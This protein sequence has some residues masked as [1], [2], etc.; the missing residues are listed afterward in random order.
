MDSIGPI[1][2]GYG[3]GL[4]L[5]TGAVGGSASERLRITSDGKL[6]LGTSAPEAEL[7]ISKNVNGTGL[8]IRIQNTSTTNFTRGTRL[9]FNVH[10][11]TAQVDA[12]YITGLKI[13]NTVGGAT[14]GG[15]LTFS[16]ANPSWDAPA[17]R[18]RIDS[19]GRVGIGTTSPGAALSISKDAGTGTQDLLT[20]NN[21]NTTY[22]TGLGP[23]IQFQTG[24]GTGL[25]S[26]SSQMVGDSFSLGSRFNITNRAG[27]FGYFDLVVN[28]SERLRVDSSGRLLVGTSSWSATST[29]VFSGN[30][31]GTANNGVLHIVRGNTAANLTS[32]ANIGK[33][34][35]S[36]SAAG[37]FAAIEVQAD[38]APGA[39]DYPGR[40][41]FS[42][43]ADG[44]ASPTERLRIDNAGQVRV[45]GLGTAASPALVV[46]GD[47]NT[48]LY[49]PGAD[50][51]AISTNGT[52]RLFVD[53]S[54]VISIGA[55]SNPNATARFGVTGGVASLLDLYRTGVAGEARLN[56]YND[57]SASAATVAGRIAGLLTTTTAGS[58]SGALLFV[59]NNSGTVGER[60]R[61]TAEGRLGLGTTTGIGGSRASILQNANAN[62]STTFTV[63]TTP[64]QLAI[65]DQSD[66]TTY[67]N[68]FATLLL[69]AGSLGAA[70]STIT[71]VRESSQASAIAFGTSAGAGGSSN[72]IERV[73]IDST[74][75]LGLGTS[76]P[77]NTLELIGDLSNSLQ[78]K[79]SINVTSNN[80]GSNGA[81]ASPSIGFS[82][83]YSTDGVRILY[84]LISAGKENGNSGNTQGYLSFYTSPVSSSGAVER[85][86]IDSTGRVGI[87]TTTPAQALDV[88]GSIAA[89]S[90]VLAGAGTAA[91]PAFSFAGDPDGGMFRP[92]VNQ[93]AFATLGTEAFRVNNS[94]RLLVGTSTSIGLNDRIQSHGTGGN[95]FGLGRFVNSGA[96]PDISFYKSR[97]GTVG[98]NTLVQAGDGL[99]N[100][101]FRGANGSTSYL[102]GATIATAVEGTPGATSMGCRLTFST[103]ADGASSPTER[104]RIDSSGNVGI[105]A[106]APTSKLHV[107]GGIRST[108]LNAVGTGGFFNAANKFG[109]DNN[110]GTTRFYSSGSNASTRGS[111]DFRIT[112]SVGSLDTSAMVLTSA[113][114]VGITVTSPTFRLELPNTATDEGG[115][116]RANQWATYSDGRIKTDREDLPYGIDAV[117][118]LEPLRYFHHNSTINEDGTIEILEEGEVSIGLVAQ[119]VDNIIP[120]VVSVPEDLTKDLC[121]LD[122]AKL[123]AVLVKAIQEQQAMIAELQTKVAALEAS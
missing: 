63:S 75:R 16:T 82:A 78:G 83:P 45:A 80:T 111:Y 117:M 26:L 46:G 96:D 32:G 52:G 51:V 120:E 6:G 91:A 106:T 18:M 68:P 53:A 21:A 44:A 28:G 90:T 122:Y 98:T 41:V 7:E 100:I 59:T 72:P 33:I 109:V 27:G 17:E 35:F 47:T 13:N 25:G 93:I 121:S 88:T 20:I 61:I 11:G 87:G 92:G 42:T 55:S 71:C 2:Y 14:S 115:R 56:F 9:N 5:Y 58:E 37:E 112:D 49:S 108:G 85:V 114:R 69:G 113:G 79:G 89:S 67:S 86:R 81:S 4:R 84:G 39:S 77:G 65:Y 73:R 54:G 64:N 95:S 118:Q 43:T 70:Y 62:Y 30:S 60:A 123:N 34:A 119:D 57:N 29:A 101:N 105:G 31:A 99:G 24:T 107:V 23:R 8:A 15:Y 66:T 38:A 48:G 1:I 22:A 74:G 36:D 40:L 76:S 10:N 19:S 116:G 104:M 94:Q 12:A 97:S 50:Q 110:N 3:D 103:T 102:S